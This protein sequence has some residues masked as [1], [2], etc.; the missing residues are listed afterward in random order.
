MTVKYVI[1]ALRDDNVRLW[2]SRHDEYV[3]WFTPDPTA[4]KF[5]PLEYDARTYLQKCL[6]STSR[7]YFLSRAADCCNKKPVRTVE[8]TVEEV[9][10][11]QIGDKEII[12]VDITAPNWGL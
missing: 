3:D 2:L 8:F 11:I 7:P 1:S 6:S 4:A 10:W 5:F 12:E 9:N